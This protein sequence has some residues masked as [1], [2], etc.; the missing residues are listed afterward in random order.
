MNE[1]EKKIAATKLIGFPSDMHLSVRRKWV[2]EP[3]YHQVDWVHTQHGGIEKL[4]AELL[5]A[6]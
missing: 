3:D 1:N 5:E 4:T 2:G 6:D